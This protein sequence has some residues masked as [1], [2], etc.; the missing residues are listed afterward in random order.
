M[1]RLSRYGERSD[2]IQ[3]QERD[4]LDGFATLAMTNYGMTI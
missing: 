2:A 3:S 1:A 4:A